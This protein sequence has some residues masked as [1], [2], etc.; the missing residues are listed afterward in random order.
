[1]RDLTDQFDREMRRSTQ[2]IE[3]VVAPYARFVCAERD[4]LESQQATLGDA[5][6]RIT[7]LRQ[8]LQHEE[9]IS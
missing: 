7:S 6:E 5:K 9:V 4:K 8:Q 3:D 1:M 2:R